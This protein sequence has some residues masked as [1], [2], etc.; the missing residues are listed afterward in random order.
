MNRR[1][2]SRRI[3]RAFNLVELLVALAISAALL[4]ATMVALDASFMAYQSTTELASTHTISR[5]V[6]YRML[7]MIRSGDEF[8]PFPLS[9]TQQIIESDFIQ[10]MTPDGQIIELN[11]TE[12]DEALYIILD[13]GT[14]SEAQHLLLEGVV[15]QYDGV[16]DRIKPFTLEYETGRQLYRATIDMMI[17]PDDNMSVQ[18]DGD[19][20][21]NIRLVASAMPRTAAFR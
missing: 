1:S 15:A 11:W 14:A 13:P 4:T 16:G 10:F 6:L 9:P 2:L 20:V 17:V 8:G 3:R 18:L 21:E 7:T 12:A 19:Y 5:M